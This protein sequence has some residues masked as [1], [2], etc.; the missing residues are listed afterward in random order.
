MINVHIKRQNGEKWDLS[1]YGCGLIVGPKWVG[2]S[3]S[4]TV[5][6][7]GFSHESLEFLRI[8]LKLKT[9]ASN[10]Q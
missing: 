9:K 5:D 2:L 1:D 7:L 3:I 6:L 10:E 8:V 4:E